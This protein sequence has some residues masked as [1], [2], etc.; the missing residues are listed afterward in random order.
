LND[1]CLVFI[2]FFPFMNHVH[3]SNY[4]YSGPV[5]D[6]VDVCVNVGHQHD[7]DPYDYTIFFFFLNYYRC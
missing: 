2:D 5:S 7:T 3:S 4:V 1:E 6:S